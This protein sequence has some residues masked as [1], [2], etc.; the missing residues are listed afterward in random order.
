VSTGTK[1]GRGRPPLA[2][3]VERISLSLPTSLLSLVAEAARR[4]SVS[5][6]EW[7]RRAALVRLSAG[8]R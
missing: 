7:L 3:D 6:A 5:V 4:E 2:D 1:R 8:G